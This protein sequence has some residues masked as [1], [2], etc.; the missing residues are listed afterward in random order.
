MKRWTSTLLLFLVLTTAAYAPKDVR[1]TKPEPFQAGEQWKGWRPDIHIAG[2]L[3]GPNGNVL[4]LD[5]VYVDPKTQR[6]SKSDIWISAKREGKWSEPQAL[7]PTINTD[8]W[9]TFPFFSPDGK[10]LYFVRDFS[11]FYSISLADSLRSVK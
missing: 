3:P 5:V 9:E 10:T 7:G 6:R 4:F 11:T 1:P 2:G 8:G